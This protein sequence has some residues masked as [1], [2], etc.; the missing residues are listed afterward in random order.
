MS[1]K[2][3]RGLSGLLTET[4]NYAGSWGCMSHSWPGIKGDEAYDMYVFAN[5][6]PS[7]PRR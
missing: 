6:A 7:G 2:T 4:A 3:I 1:A 5:C